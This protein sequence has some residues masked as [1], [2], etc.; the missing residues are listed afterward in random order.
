MSEEHINAALSATGLKVSVIGIGNA[1]GQVALAAAKKSIPVFVMNTSVK[2]LDDKVLSGP[3]KCY[4]IG[5]G[6]GSGKNRDN[7]MELLKTNGNSSIKD[8]FVN[9]YFKQTVEPADIVFVTFSTAGG[10]GSGIGP[11]MARMIHQAY[12]NKV[13]I[14][15]GILPKNVESVMGQSNTIACVDDMTACGTPYMLSDLSFYENESQEVSFKKI[16]EYM[17][18]TMCVIRGDYLKMSASGMADERDMLTII[19]EPGYMTVHM[20]DGITEQM[21]SGKT[22][23]GYLVDEVK[24]SPAC[25]IQRDGLLQY[26]LLISN[27]NSSVS[28]PMKIGDYQELYDFIGEPKATYANYAV[29][30]SQTE[31][32]VISI[33]SGLTIPMDRF[34]TARAK[35]KQHK[36]K[37]ES[38]SALNLSDDREKFGVKG[39]DD[40]KNII[41]GSQ[42]KSEAD[43]SFLDD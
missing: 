19:S 36:D 29:D 24:S 34:T 18:E 40:T 26:S 9:P 17:A 20:K 2:D 10:T 27:V 25:R 42:K 28:D 7:A 43:L 13:V 31:F 30:D 11:T 38:K 41:M 15:Y 1:G 6:R 37:F 14:P 4:Q 22:L 23:Q 33:T 21:L 8:I 12:K 3:I 35:I 32:Q 16:G 5:D 39:N